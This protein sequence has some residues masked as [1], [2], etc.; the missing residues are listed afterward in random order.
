M[1]KCLN[2][3]KKS[4]SKRDKKGV[5]N[6]EEQVTCKR[7]RLMAT[8]SEQSG[9][10]EE[11]QD[12]EVVRRWFSRLEELEA[13]GEMNG[14]RGDRVKTSSMQQ[15]MDLLGESTHSPSLSPSR[16]SATSELGKDVITRE[17]D[18]CVAAEADCLN[19]HEGMSLPLLAH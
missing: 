4:V 10:L 19:V 3:G 15:A 14:I 11:D 6:E 17:V 5:S 2:K 7:R 18:C 8:T 12:T 16:E 13:E 9:G 1:D